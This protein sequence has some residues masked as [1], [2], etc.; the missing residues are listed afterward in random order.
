MIPFL[1][2]EWGALL[3]LP[4]ERGI[5]PENYAFKM[6]R[7]LEQRADEEET[8][9][10]LYVAVTRAADYLILS[11]GLPYDRRYQSPWMKLLARHF[12]LSTGAPAIDPYL[13]RL[14]LAAVPA[15]QIPEIHV[16]HARPQ[17]TFKAAKKRK[18]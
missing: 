3:G 1:H 14:S 18:N 10:L 17:S 16:H 15:A 2:P 7:T 13:G 8:V 11:A 9:R 12:D 4:A 5:V 6:H